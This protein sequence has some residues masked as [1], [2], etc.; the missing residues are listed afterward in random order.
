MIINSY[1]D[2]NIRAAAQ[3]P[4]HHDYHGRITDPSANIC[5]PNTKLKTDEFDG[6][7]ILLDGTYIESTTYYDQI[8][9]RCKNRTENLCE[10]LFTSGFN[11]TT[12]KFIHPIQV[13]Q[14]GNRNE[15]KSGHYKSNNAESCKSCP[16]GSFQDLSG[17]KTCRKCIPGTFQKNTGQSDCSQ[18]VINKYQD[19]D[20]QT[21]CKSCATGFYQ[22]ISGSTS[23]KK[24]CTP[25][26]EHLEWYSANITN[27]SPQSLP[28]GLYEKVIKGDRNTFHICDISGNFTTID[29]S[30]NFNCT[31]SHYKCGSS[32]VLQN[33]S[34]D[35]TI[36]DF[37]KN[38][39]GA[40]SCKLP[41]MP[42]EQTKLKGYIEFYKDHPSEQFDIF[43]VVNQQNWNKFKSGK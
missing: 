23:C 17:Q 21:T 1:L 3:E 13:C 41:V 43:S 10:T 39:C 12:Y 34:Y 14:L 15:C 8:I 33:A 35:G 20:G 6:V 25:P 11:T 30:A 29:N 37:K 26:D 2:D 5:T 38:C 40:T 19:E 22:D 7:N 9:S 31:E 18:C 32:L 24:F 4:L 27:I 42:Y 28:Y 36:K 16:P